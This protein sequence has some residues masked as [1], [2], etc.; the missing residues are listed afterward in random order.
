MAYKNVHE[1]G[2]VEH[3]LGEGEAKR[4]LARLAAESKK[5]HQLLPQSGRDNGSIL[6]NSDRPSPR[7]VR[8]VLIRVIEKTPKTV[9]RES[10]EELAE[11][12]VKGR[13]IRAIDERHSIDDSA[14]GLSTV[15]TLLEVPFQPGGL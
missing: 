8:E 13:T 1:T 6:E 2:Q 15:S 9:T 10:Q 11:Y 12:E 3:L 14:Q 4:I 7:E 5:E